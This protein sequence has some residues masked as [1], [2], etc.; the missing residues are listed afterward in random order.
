MSSQEDLSR[1]VAEVVRRLMASDS[2]PSAPQAE[3]LMA[4]DSRPSAPQAE[5]RIQDTGPQ[6]TWSLASLGGVSGLPANEA[7]FEQESWNRGQVA[8]RYNKNTQGQSERLPNRTVVSQFRSD[9]RVLEC[10]ERL[11]TLSQFSGRL[12]AVDRLRI[13]Q[14]AVI[15][16]ALREELNRL[17]IVIERVAFRSVDD[18]SPD[19]IVASPEHDSRDAEV[20]VVLW[21]RDIRTNWVRALDRSWIEVRESKANS[22]EELRAEIEK[23]CI[24][25]GAQRACSLVL[26][27][28]P[29]ALACV[30]N[31]SERIRAAAVQSTSC[32]REALSSMQA[33]VVI[34]SPAMI[35]RHTL[36]RIAQA[37]A[38]RLE[39]SG[40]SRQSYDSRPT[41]GRRGS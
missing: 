36:L 4:S 6:P 24:C 17:G 3:P 25:D 29:M 19:F 26:T 38:G 40:N 11:L 21:D 23:E 32:V 1:I 14:K 16:P 35:S 5:P 28:Q 7:R 10:R 39:G 15:T 34:A 18:R 31:R 2:R 22:A 33:N 41:R 8:I 20:R 27:K 30:L 13:E 9:G 12:D 37:L